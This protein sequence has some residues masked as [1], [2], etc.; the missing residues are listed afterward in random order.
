M[1]IMLRNRALYIAITVLFLLGLCVTIW[2]IYQWIPVTVFKPC[3]LTEQ[4]VIIDPGHGGEDGG[5]VSLSG[6]KESIINLSISHK[7]NDLFH[8]YGVNSIM[9]REEDISVHDSGA[10]SIRE[11]KNSDI[12]NRV[13]MVKA[14]DNAL[15]ISIHQNSFPETKYHGMQIFFANE[16]SKELAKRMQDNVRVFLDANNKRQALKIQP[17]VYLLNHVS[18]PAVLAECGFMS[19]PEEALLLQQ[20]LYQKKIAITIAAAFFREPQT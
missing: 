9:T 16:S 7:L 11:K 4:T 18:C 19:N 5:A 17:S 1:I 12:H 2:E 20:D 15:L 3:R 10:R 8:F 13:A 6:Q 14:V